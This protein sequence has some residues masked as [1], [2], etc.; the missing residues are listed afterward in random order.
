VRE[1]DPAAPAKG[2]INA[3]G[4]LAARSTAILWVYGAAACCGSQR[5][6][7]AYFQRHLYMKVRASA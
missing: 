1:N 4:L 5:A 3:Q 6:A 7:D 2:A